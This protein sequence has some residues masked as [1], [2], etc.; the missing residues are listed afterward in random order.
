MRARLPSL[1]G[2]PLIGAAL[3]VSCLP[4]A[5]PAFAQQGGAH[6]AQCAAC[7]GVDGIARSA[8][9]PHL[10][11]QNDLYLFNQIMAFRSGRRPHREMGY[12]ARHISERDARELAEYYAAL[13]P[14]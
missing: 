14:R 12:M 13:P 6:I 11:G 2:A 8:D 10:A 3:M 5:A 9:V 7:H 4:A 1:T